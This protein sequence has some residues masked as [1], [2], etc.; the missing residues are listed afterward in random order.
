MF[1]VQKFDSLGYYSFYAT[2]LEN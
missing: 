2:C 1:E